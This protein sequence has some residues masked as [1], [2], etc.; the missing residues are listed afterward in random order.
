M[1]RSC[2]NIKSIDDFKKFAKYREYAIEMGLKE[3]AFI[4]CWSN[5]SVMNPDLFDRLYEEYLRLFNADKL[6]ANDDD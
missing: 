3:T 1:I 4:I 5:S 6:K 2:N